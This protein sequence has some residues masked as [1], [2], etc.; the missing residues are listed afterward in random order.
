MTKLVYEDGDGTELSGG[1][2]RPLEVLELGA[3][4]AFNAKASKAS[5]SGPGAGHAGAKA[6]FLN[7]LATLGRILGCPLDIEGAKAKLLEARMERSN[8]P[9]VGA[10]IGQVAVAGKIAKDAGHAFGRSELASYVNVLGAFGRMPEAR[11]EALAQAALADLAGQAG[12]SD[13]R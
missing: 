7:G 1:S 4:Q 6:A 8:V 11:R 5:S 13:G 10:L 9:L 3:A 2:G 12:G